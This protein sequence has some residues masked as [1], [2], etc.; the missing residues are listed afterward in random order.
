[1][2]GLWGIGSHSCHSHTVDKFLIFLGFTFCVK[3]RYKSRWTHLVQDPV[4]YSIPPD[5]LI[6]AAVITCQHAVHGWGRNSHVSSWALALS[7]LSPGPAASFFKCPEVFFPVELLFIYF[8]FLQ[9]NSKCSPSANFWCSFSGSSQMTVFSLVYFNSGQTIPLETYSFSLLDPK[10]QLNTSLL[11]S[12]L[13]GSTHAPVI[14]VTVGSITDHGCCKYNQPPQA[15]RES[16]RAKDWEGAMR[17]T[18]TSETT[19]KILKLLHWPVKRLK[20]TKPWT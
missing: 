17:R 16:Q 9:K 3:S 6:S 7:L 13:W 14:L 20:T 10:C 5:W 2:S 18:M 15:S 8:F 1:M 19:R 12:F 4:Y 11:F